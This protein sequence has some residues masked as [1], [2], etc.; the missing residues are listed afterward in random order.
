MMSSVKLQS[1][2]A[3]KL[4]P[5]RHQYISVYSKRFYLNLF[6]SQLYLHRN[7]HIPKLQKQEVTTGPINFT[8]AEVTSF[9][10]GENRH[11]VK[12]KTDQGLTGGTSAP[13]PPA[14]ASRSQE[15]RP[16]QGSSRTN[17]HAG[18]GEARVGQPLP[19]SPLHT[20]EDIALDI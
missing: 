1:G 2:S 9:F 12:H 5:Y 7:L 4:L 16:A 17:A 15:D 19:R 13:T 11:N 18:P 8:R 20:G 6:I 10:A 3:P 14:T